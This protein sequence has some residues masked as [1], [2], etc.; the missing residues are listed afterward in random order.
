MTTTTTT[1]RATDA[2]IAR[3]RCARAHGGNHDLAAIQ[4]HTMVECQG[5]GSIYTAEQV[6]AARPGIMG[7]GGLISR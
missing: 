1:T 6:I 3:V 2:Q 4:G 5:C 7:E